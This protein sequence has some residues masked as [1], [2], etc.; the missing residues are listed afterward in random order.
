[1]R[2]RQV[3]SRMIGLGETLAGKP[4]Q[5]LAG[6]VVAWAVACTCQPVNSEHGVCLEHRMG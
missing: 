2:C 6:R 3:D 4:W 5:K 1:M